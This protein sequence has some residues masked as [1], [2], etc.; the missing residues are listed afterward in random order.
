MPTLSLLQYLLGAAAGSLVG[1]TL[2]LV[3]GGGS[4]LA[5]PLMVYL[6]GVDNPHVA[7]GTSALA[8]AANAAANLLNHARR[9]NVKWPC[10][11][12]FALVGVVGAFFG[13]SLGKAFDGQKLLAL[14]ALL[15]LLVAALMLRGRASEG[16]AAVALGRGNAPR[17][18][19]F[20]GL[21]GALS[22]FFGIG[23]G[24]LIVPGLMAATR[25]PI[26]FAVGSSLVAVTAFGLTTALN[27]ARS[28]LV[29]WPLAV[30]FIGGGVAG[31]LC[32]AWLATRLSR[33][34]GTLNLVSAAMIGA[35]AL[36]MLYRSL[37]ALGVI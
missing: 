8:V 16:D 17:L 31:G 20:G 5:V 21:A 36:Y 12:L 2:G 14:F 28:G 29:D 33:S 4:I 30:V 24:F 3:G 19:A 34:Q 37:G 10:A 18:A 22:G 27:Y 15:M 7:I 6:V 26:L 1:F 9:G 13:S 23:G 32:G 25:M 11:S 35:T